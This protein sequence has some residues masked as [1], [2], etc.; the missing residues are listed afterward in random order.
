MEVAEEGIVNEAKDEQP[1]KTL[2]L[3][4][5]TEDGISME[6]REEQPEKAPSEISIRPTQ[7]V[8]NV[9]FVQ[10]MKAFL[11]LLDSIMTII[12]CGKCYI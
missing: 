7:R 11:Q 6:T 8:T 3:S 5:G 1:V 12:I 9:N 10:P 4:G 2:L